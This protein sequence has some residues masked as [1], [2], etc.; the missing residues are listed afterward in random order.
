MSAYC[1]TCGQAPCVLLEER[2]ELRRLCD[3]RPINRYAAERVAA[4]RTKVQVELTRSELMHAMAE[5]RNPT[6]GLV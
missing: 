6:G 4:A 1:E 3:L 5:A 2:E